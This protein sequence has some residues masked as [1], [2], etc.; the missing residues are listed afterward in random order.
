MRSF[1]LLALTVAFVSGDARSADDKPED[2]PKAAKTRKLLKTKL[3]EV[4]FKDTRLEDVMDELKSEVKG[5]NV[6][7]DTKG[8]VSRN[9]TLTFSG[10]NV[11]LEDALDGLFSKAALGYIII[12]KKGGTYDGLLEVR[13]GKERGYPLKKN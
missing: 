2:T 9:K 13:Q 1:A 7:L 8:G 11:T 12:S 4:S 5:L 6:L 3:K 10:K